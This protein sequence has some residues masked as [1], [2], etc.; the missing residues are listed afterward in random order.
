MVEYVHYS[1]DS[2]SRLKQQRSMSKSGIRT[3]LIMY[4]M[5][6]ST[7]A[8]WM[9]VYKLTYKDLHGAQRKEECEQKVLTY[10]FIHSFSCT[11]SIQLI[12]KMIHL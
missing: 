11:Y 10:P 8:D 4:V 7:L 2:I 9:H 5:M 6:Q 3:L 12:Q 1:A